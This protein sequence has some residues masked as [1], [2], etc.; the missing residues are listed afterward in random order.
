MP[1]NT[2]IQ[3]QKTHHTHTSHMHSEEGEEKN[4]TGLNKFTAFL[5]GVLEN[6]H[7]ETIY[8]LTNF[9]VWLWKFSP[10]VWWYKM[11]SLPY[12]LHAIKPVWENSEGSLTFHTG[13]KYALTIR[14]CRSPRANY[15]KSSQSQLGY[16]NKSFSTRQSLNIIK[17]WIQEAIPIS[18]M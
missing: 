13:C 7:R 16:T 18:L 15:L 4:G 1:P 2:H 14:K 12:L 5:L 8:F 10:S 11:K 9:S 6:Y 17:G 3:K